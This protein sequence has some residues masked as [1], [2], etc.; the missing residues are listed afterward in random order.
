M[1][2]AGR[3][4]TSSCGRARFINNRAAFNYTQLNTAA[5]G[6]DP[7]YRK[8]AGWIVGERSVHHALKNLK[9][10]R[11]VSCIGWYGF[12]NVSWHSALSV[13]RSV[14]RSGMAETNPSPGL[15]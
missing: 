11:L 6:E 13:M 7:A 14:K 10:L 1:G 12:V 3:T 9:A 8:A 15:F 2:A 4:A 5:A